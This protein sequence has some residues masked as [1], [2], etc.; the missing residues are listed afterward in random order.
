MSP[1]KP[2]PPVARKKNGEGSQTISKQLVVIDQVYI[3]F[4]CFG[5]LRTFHL[6][7]ESPVEV[8]VP[9]E[10]L[11]E[12]HWVRCPRACLFKGVR[13]TFKGVWSVAP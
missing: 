12:P 2:S 3:R 13:R 7:K 9:C 5:V 6:S 11:R 10:A 8:I 4:R 1:A